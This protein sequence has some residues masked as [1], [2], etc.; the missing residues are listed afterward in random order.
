MAARIDRLFVVSGLLFAFTGLLLAAHMG[1]ARDQS[2]L[3]THAHLMLPGF[4]MSSVYGLCYR[5]W[6]ALKSG[7]SP[8][9]HYIAHTMGAAFLAIALFLFASGSASP[10]AVPLDIAATLL[11]MIGVVVFFVDLLRRGEG[12]PKT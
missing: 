4:L 2:Q 10:I 8:I 9:V 3:Y 7:L 1:E 11:L 6:P 12:P 5:S